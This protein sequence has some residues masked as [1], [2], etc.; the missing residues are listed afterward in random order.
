MAVVSEPQGPIPTVLR[1]RFPPSPA[2][3][4][5]GTDVLFPVKGAYSVEEQSTP[6]GR[7]GV[8]RGATT[9]R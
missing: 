1:A 8:K 7:V 5:F 6:R 4:R 9:F 2:L 3:Y